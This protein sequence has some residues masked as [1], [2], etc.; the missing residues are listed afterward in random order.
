ME[1]NMKKRF[2]SIL[3]AAVFLTGIVSVYPVSAAETPTLTVASVTGSAGSQVS[4]TIAVSNNPGVCTARLNVAYDSKLTLVSAVNGSLLPSAMY[5]EPPTGSNPGAYIWASTTN[6]TAN[7]TLL[8]LNFQVAADA[9][10]LLPVTVTYGTNDI[11][12]ASETPVAFTIV[13]GGVSVFNTPLIYGSDI[14]AK[15]NNEFIYK[16][17]ITNNPGFV[18]TV[19]NLNYDTNKL[20]YIPYGSN[21]DGAV[22][23][24][25]EGV[26]NSFVI[27][28]QQTATGVVIVASG[29]VY[30][31]TDD[32]VLFNLKFK[33]ID[34]TFDT[35]KINLTVP[36]LIGFGGVQPSFDVVSGVITRDISEPILIGKLGDASNDGNVTA[37]D[38]VVVLRVVA[39]LQSAPT[40][41]VFKLANVNND[42]NIT[43]YDAVLILRYVAGLST[44]Y[45]IGQPFYVDP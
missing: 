27:N 29:S 18:A 10:G 37:Y 26:E 23:D 17:S 20:Q 25:F 41:N 39:G 19:I 14:T 30:N 42:S 4:V 24:V 2:I 8:T 7:G 22:G 13:N 32:G 43:A 40:G 3:L 44:G 12:N 36:E 33:V 28:E 45:N 1:F 38:A 16:I 11:H 34:N 9:S 5:Q 6:S 21:T 15:Y 31:A 35:T